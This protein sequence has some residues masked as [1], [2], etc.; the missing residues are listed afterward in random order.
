MSSRAAGL[1]AGDSW[2]VH[3]GKSCSGLC[4]RWRDASLAW[5][6]SRRSRLATGRRGSA[7]ASEPDVRSRFTDLS[8]LRTLSQRVHHSTESEHGDGILQA[9]HKQQ[10]LSLSHAT[11]GPPIALLRGDKLRPALSAAPESTGLS[12]TAALSLISTP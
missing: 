12:P 1:T 6:Q 9:P 2:F 3:A 11:S 7:A 8:I 5:R 4:P 10:I